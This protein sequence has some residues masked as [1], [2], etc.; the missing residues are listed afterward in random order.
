MREDSEVCLFSMTTTHTNVHEKGIMHLE[1]MAGKCGVE[2][3]VWHFLAATAF[4]DIVGWAKALQSNH[5][6]WPTS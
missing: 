1:K 6:H 3:L 5:N 4:A 2:S